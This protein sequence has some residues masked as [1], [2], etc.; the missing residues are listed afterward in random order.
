MRAKMAT[1]MAMVMAVL[2]FVKAEDVLNI[3]FM[4]AGTSFSG[5]PCEKII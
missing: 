1:S 3:L 2:H 4:V 5:T